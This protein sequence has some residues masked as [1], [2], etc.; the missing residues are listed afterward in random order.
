MPPYLAD[1]VT[2]TP[3]G[4]THAFMRATHAKT[5]SAVLSELAN[6]AG[7]V[8]RGFGFDEAAAHAVCV[9]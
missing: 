3:P 4:R 2:A 6:L 5:L 9:G 1:T 8:P 7:V